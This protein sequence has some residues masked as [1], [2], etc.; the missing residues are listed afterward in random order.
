M[1]TELKLKLQ[2]LVDN[3]LPAS[4][5]A[6]MTARVEADPEARAFVED[7]RRTREVLSSAHIRTST[8]EAPWESVQAR[9]DQPDPQYG[10]RLI[11]FPQALTAVAAL[12]LLSLILYVPS[13]T[14]APQG[15]QETDGLDSAVYLVETDLENATPIVYIDQPSG[16]TLVWVAELQEEPE[17]G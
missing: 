1:D 9:M 6:K 8:R 17:K 15:I 16:W 3:E 5:A 2:A 11:T 7:L 4:E 10:N 14:P 13:R 12:L